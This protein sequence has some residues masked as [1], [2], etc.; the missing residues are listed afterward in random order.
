M[1]FQSFLFL[2][3]F[4]PAAAAC[5]FV[6]RRFAPPVI[7]KLWIVAASLIFYAGGRIEGIPF[8]LGSIAANTFL[9]Y[10]IMAASERKRFWLFIGVTSNVLFLCFVK[11]AAFAVET[12]NG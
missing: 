10:R 12:F 8:L 1:N 11:Y 9:V 2:L 4:L 3:I 7:S 6:L 5:Y